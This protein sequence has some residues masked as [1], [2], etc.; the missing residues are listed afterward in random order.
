MAPRKR[1]GP[2]TFETE[3][4]PVE[5]Q[6]FQGHDQHGANEHPPQPEVGHPADER[7]APAKLARQDSLTIGFLAAHPAPHAWP[8]K[9]ARQSP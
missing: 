4:A 1:S 3:R 7:R 2:L 9:V 6:R 8:A 5:D